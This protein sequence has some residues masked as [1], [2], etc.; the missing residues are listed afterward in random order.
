MNGK[1]TFANVWS[2][3]TTAMESPGTFHLSSVSWARASN[4]SLKAILV[5]L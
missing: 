3:S 4:S 1:L 2:P 5:A